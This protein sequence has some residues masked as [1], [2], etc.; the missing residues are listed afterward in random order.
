MGPIT[1]CVKPGR[2]IS[3]QLVLSFT[4]LA[5]TRSIHALSCF[6]LN[7]L[8]LRSCRTRQLIGIPMPGNTQLLTDKGLQ[9]HAPMLLYVA[10]STLKEC[11]TLIRL[12]QTSYNSAGSQ[13]SI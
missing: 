11:W 8:S 12:M 2:V 3:P 5:P 10:L 7:R 13:G 1:P 4:F 9:V 6:P